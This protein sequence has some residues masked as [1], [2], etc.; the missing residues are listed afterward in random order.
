MVVF[1]FLYDGFIQFKGWYILWG[2][3]G[4]QLVV[5]VNGNENINFY[6]YFFVVM[7]DGL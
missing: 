5:V 2:M 4:D 1:G 7:E 6:I 3:G